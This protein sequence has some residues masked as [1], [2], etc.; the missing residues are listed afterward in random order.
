M[1]K[2]YRKS[3]TTPCQPVTNL[4][5][6]VWSLTY[7]TYL[8]LYVAIGGGSLDWVRPGPFFFQTSPDLLN[9]TDPVN[10]NGIDNVHVLQYP[11]LIDPADVSR[12]FENSGQTAYLYYS[13]VN[14]DGT[15]D[16]A[17]VQ[18]KFAP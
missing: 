3:K 2:G 9:W 4:S 8:N 6:L 16:L 10:I 13:R 7:N 11:S 1:G 14:K 15:R 12:N 5:V 17:R 18:I